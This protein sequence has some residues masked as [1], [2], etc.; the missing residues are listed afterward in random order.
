MTDTDFGIILAMLPCLCVLGVAVAVATQPGQKSRKPASWIKPQNQ[1]RQ[2]YGSEAEQRRFGESVKERQLQPLV[3][4]AD[5][6]LVCGY[7][8]FVCGTLVGMVEFD[9]TILTD[10][11][12]ESQ[13][14][15]YRLTE[16][17]QR[18]DLSP[19]EMWQS[20]VELM[21]M[22]PAWQMKD[23]A[24]HLHLD[25]SMVTRLLSPSKCIPAWQEALKEGK[26]GISDCYAASKIPEDQAGMLALKLSGATRDQIE[27]AGRKGRTATVPEVKTG[28]VRC[29]LSS[30]ATVVVSGPEMSLE[31]YI[32]ALQSA[33]EFARKA[34]KESL[35]VKTAEKV[36]KD[37][38]KLKS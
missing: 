16:N 15:V 18:K 13:I 27:Q 10:A 12:T 32:N 2:D 23:L 30:G 1:I 33:L 9:V 35:D 17:I 31:E 24:E 20:C 14:K 7:R 22:N 21:S 4:L 29:P 28:R 34:N 11:L 25:P 3:C 38:S 36:W 6:T 26:V 19:Y 5:G 37:K 8:R